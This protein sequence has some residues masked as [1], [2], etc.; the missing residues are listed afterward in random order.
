MNE[1]PLHD[2]QII[3]MGFNPIL[4]EMEILLHRCN[5]SGQYFLVNIR[6]CGVKSIEAIDG[7][8]LNDL[9][10][11]GGGVYEAS[12]ET[13]ADIEVLDIS[14]PE[15]W[16]LVITADKIHYEE[17]PV[18]EKEIDDQLSKSISIGLLQPLIAF[19][20]KSKG[21]NPII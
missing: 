5:E 2:A 12:I 3:Y 10:D 8:D 1:L 15:Y 13:K 18:K 6:I 14:G 9:F 20:D 19:F 16:Q 21:P 4:S 11:S 17:R 7:K